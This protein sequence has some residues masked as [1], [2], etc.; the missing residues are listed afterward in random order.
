[1]IFVS[2]LLLGLLFLLFLFAV[3]TFATFTVFE[4]LLGCE[5]GFASLL[6]LLLRG[7]LL[8]VGFLFL[9]LRDCS[10]LLLLFERRDCLN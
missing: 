3:V 8:L 10:H 1:M 5:L 4:G 9:D 2:T 7:L 6:T